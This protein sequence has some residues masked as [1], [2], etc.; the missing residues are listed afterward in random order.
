[1]IIQQF[2]GMDVM[3]RILRYRK[4]NGLSIPTSEKEMHMAMQSDGDK[5][6]SKKEKREIQ[7]ARAK[8]SFRGHR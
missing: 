2:Q 4:E 5:V 6:M 8:K 7:T 3:H 1:M